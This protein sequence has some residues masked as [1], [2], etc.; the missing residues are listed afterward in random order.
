[1]WLRDKGLWFIPIPKTGT[2]T[3]RGIFKEYEDRQD[4]GGHPTYLDAKKFLENHAGEAPKFFSVVRK[5]DDRMVS[6]IRYS[7]ISHC[8]NFNSFDNRISTPEEFVDKSLREL[9]AIKSVYPIPSLIY[10]SR[11]TPTLPNTYEPVTHKD[12]RQRWKETKFSR[13]S[14]FVYTGQAFWLEGSTVDVTL[15]KMDNL[16]NLANWLRD[17]GLHVA[18]IPHKNRNVDYVERSGFKGEPVSKDM[19]R[20][21]PLFDTMMDRYQRDWAVYKEAN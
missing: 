19:V 1:M 15:F 8:R 5:P 20:G 14:S 6:A 18:N 13:M 4:R 7:W 9:I 3:V 11:V 16:A 17:H 21:H 10:E 2:Q 12:W